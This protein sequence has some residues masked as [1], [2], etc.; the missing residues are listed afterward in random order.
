MSVNWY[1][2]ARSWT[3]LNYNKRTLFD[4]LIPFAYLYGKWLVITR[5]KSITHFS[6]KTVFYLPPSQSTYD[7]T[8][9]SML[10]SER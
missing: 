2:I 1:Y 9:K 4:F 10:Y 8:I 6:E 5:S 3:T 7:D